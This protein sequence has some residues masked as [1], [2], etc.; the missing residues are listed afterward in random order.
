M[1]KFWVEFKKFAL[2]GNMVELAVGVVIGGA[3]GKIVSSLVNDIIMPLFGVILGGINFSELSFTIGNSVIKYGMFIQN[4]IDFII[5]SLS[6]FLVLRTFLKFTKKGLHTKEPPVKPKS[7]E[8]V[9]LEEIC[10][11]LKQ[12]Q[13]A[14]TCPCSDENKN[15]KPP[16][17]SLEG[18]RAD[19]SV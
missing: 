2:K 15:L 5:I 12:I 19:E 8:A 6:I 10:D 14:V 7:D 16:Q 17:A 4:I 3:F 11:S 1:L 9:L 13:K 18:E